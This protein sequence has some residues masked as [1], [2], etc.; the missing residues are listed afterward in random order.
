MRLSSSFP[1]PQVTLHSV[2][3]NQLDQPPLTA[4]KEQRVK[5]NVKFPLCLDLSCWQN[6]ATM[7]LLRR[8]RK[9]QGLIDHEHSVAGP[10]DKENSLSTKRKEKENDYCS[11]QS[12]ATTHQMVSGNFAV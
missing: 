11:A 6:K 4:L 10:S 12:T 2:D 5:R 8:K 9:T 7:I 1:L 3:T